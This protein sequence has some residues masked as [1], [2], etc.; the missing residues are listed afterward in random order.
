M[1]AISAVLK[2]QNTFQFISKYDLFKKKKIHCLL[3]SLS[4]DNFFSFRDK[5]EPERLAL[6]GL[7][8][9]TVAMEVT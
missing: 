8:D 7:A 9:T 2:L 6:N 1:T 5:H 4:S 3:L